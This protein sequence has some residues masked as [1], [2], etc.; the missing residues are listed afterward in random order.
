MQNSLYVYLCIDRYHEARM[1][2][3][4]VD[5]GPHVFKVRLVSGVRRH[6]WEIAR[7]QLGLS[8]TIAGALFFWHHLQCFGR[9][10][11]SKQKDVGP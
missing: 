1:Y 9:V 8:S 5:V 2:T 11:V 7:K 4:G 10:P 3:Y 6:Y